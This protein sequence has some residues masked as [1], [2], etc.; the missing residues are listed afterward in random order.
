MGNMNQLLKKIGR[1]TIR[2]NFSCTHFFIT[3]IK[4][5]IELTLYC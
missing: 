3:L 5:K 2:I 1:K 4:N